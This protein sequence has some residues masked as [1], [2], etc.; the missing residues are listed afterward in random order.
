[1]TMKF[2]TVK[3]RLT[4]LLGTAAA[5][6][7]DVVG[8]QRQNQSADENGGLTRV[9]VFY[10]AGN[11]SKSSSRT[12]P[13]RHEATFVVNLTVTRAAA[14][15]LSTLTDSESTPAQWAAALTGMQDASELADL[16]I[17]ELFDD[18]YQELMDNRNQDLSFDIGFVRDRWISD[19]AKNQPITRGEY[20]ILTA[21]LN[22]NCMIEEYLTGA[23]TL[24]HVE[25]STQIKINE[26]DYTQNIIA[27]EGV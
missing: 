6:R 27:V 26:D 17:D 18:I 20:V 4:E 16:A 15:D 22:Y 8:H 19:F 12:G 13:I 9:Q 24:P 5:G 2:R 10:E 21:S 14:G 11:F 7:Y 25:T 1:M 23:S 3:T